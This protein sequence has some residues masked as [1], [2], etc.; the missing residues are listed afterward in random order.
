MV[1][2]GSTYTLSG[3]DRPVILE[4]ITGIMTRPE[5]RALPSS[6]VNASDHR[7]QFGSLVKSSSTMSLESTGSDFLAESA[8]H[9]TR[10]LFIHNL[11]TQTSIV[12]DKL[13]L[14]QAAASLVT[15]AAKTLAHAFYFCP[16]VAEVLVRLW[17]TP[18][19][20]IRHV[21]DEFGLSGIRSGAD[22]EHLVSAFPKCL[23]PLRFTS[24][25]SIIRGLRRPPPRVLAMRG[26]DWH[27]AW[28]TRWCGRD[29]DLFFV[30]V[31]HWHILLEDFL[32]LD[33][34]ILDK[35]RA[36]AFVLVH[37][38]I[39]TVFQSTIHHPV[40]SAHGAGP[41]A[42]P[43]TTFDDVLAGA[44]ASAD[45]LPLPTAN[46]TRQM[47]ENRL[48]MLLRDVLSDRSSEHDVA[49]R[50]FATYFVKV[51]QA[52]ARRISKFD[53]DACFTLCDFLEEAA[54]IFDRYRG[55]HP[56]APEIVDWAFWLSVCQQISESQNTMS[57]I[58]LF[59]FL[60]STWGIIVSDERR[61]KELCIGWLLAPAT[62]ERFFYH[63]CPMSRAYYMRLLCWRLA[64]VVEPS[65]VDL[66]VDSLVALFL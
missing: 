8:Y 58:R 55:H 64:R 13:A 18:A 44:D 60:Y 37:A 42:A 17:G 51:L 12:V 25:P 1:D 2:S 36:P 22:L 50:T 21:A 57:E 41:E 32:P 43:A 4:G 53:H 6:V 28:L 56:S 26:I 34:D 29:T 52:A 61:K 27:G 49:S 46:V 10:N 66:Y 30:F 62:F 45:A 16:G 39:M 48:I 31:K 33:V 63:W 54:Y 35:A 40:A 24:A 7:W 20:N 14:R 47:A 11:L 19:N 23:H 5:W 65:E 9:N 38:Q 59:A 15:F 3:T